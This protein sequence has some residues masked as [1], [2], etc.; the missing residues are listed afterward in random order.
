MLCIKVGKDE[1]K[2]S[3]LKMEQQNSVRPSHRSQSQLE[4]QFLYVDIN[5]FFASCEQQENPRLQNKPIAVVPMLANTTFCI[6]ASYEAKSFGV[7]TG[8]R[9][10]EAKKL[11][12]IL[13]LV[14]ARHDIYVRYHHKIRDVI[15]TCAPLH[16][17]PSIDEFCI[18]LT[19]SQSQIQNAL[20]LG[21]KIK[22]ALQL[23][24][25][26]A[27]TCSIGIATNRLLAKMAADFIKPNGLSYILK[28]EIIQ[29]LAPLHLTDIPGIGKKMLLRLQ[30]QNI[31]SM[32]DLLYLNENQMKAA[33]G[34]NVGRNYYYWLKGEHFREGRRP[35]QIQK[36]LSHEHVLP[37][38]ERS[39]SGAL[40]V[41]KKLATKIGVRLRKERLMCKCLILSIRFRGG[42]HWTAQCHF[43][44]NQNTSYLI[45]KIQQLY[46][47]APFKDSP[48]KVSVT[49]TELASEEFHQLSFFENE[50]QNLLF[51]TVDMI[52]QK[53]GQNT[54]FVSS[55]KDSLDK[56]PTRISF[57]RIPD[58]SELEN[59]QKIVIK[60][61]TSPNKKN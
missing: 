41:L 45:E 8:M 13:H 2:D 28:E 49:L 19:G 43:H 23:N 11:C 15:E 61:A 47:K 14:K 52:N 12:P 59:S 33:W 40:L 31:R 48:F 57:S 7:K 42:E 44:E 5:A 35:D 3:S 56:A 51:K 22:Q 9:V 32:Q 58:L 25:G 17:T 4:V 10:D 6:A 24:I 26:T 60:S 27:L 34:G 39:K 36:S 53:F 1:I 21:K 50:K 20:H 46:S 37:P 54:I 18:E 30:S 38:Q 55:L 16:S 29:K